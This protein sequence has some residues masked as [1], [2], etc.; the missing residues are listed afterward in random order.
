MLSARARLPVLLLL[1]GISCTLASARII[2]VDGDAT[3]EGDGSSWADAYKHL[4]DGLAVAS[5][6]D[7]DSNDVEVNDL[8]ELPAEPGPSEPVTR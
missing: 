7:F 6:G 1:V 8:S 2:Y 4:Q 5:D 3:G